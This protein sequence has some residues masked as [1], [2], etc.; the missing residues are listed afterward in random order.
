M[1]IQCIPLVSKHKRKGTFSLIYGK[2]P[3]E[4]TVELF[5]IK[6]CGV[7]AGE[8]EKTVFFFVIYFQYGD[9]LGIFLLSLIFF[10]HRYSIVI[11]F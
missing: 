7:D 1:E 11:A 2:T 6:R 5:F 9:G 10:K 4:H 3:L 8:E